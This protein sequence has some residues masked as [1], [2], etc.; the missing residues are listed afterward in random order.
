MTMKALAKAILNLA[1]FME[2]SSDDVIDPDS[3][4]GVREGVRDVH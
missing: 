4:E 3:A 2:L 1:A